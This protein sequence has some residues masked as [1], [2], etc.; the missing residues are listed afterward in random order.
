MPDATQPSAPSSSPS[1]S[2]PASPAAA[3]AAPS[4]APSN[5]SPSP[6]PAAAA[7]SPQPS[8]PVARPAYVPE[9]DWDA[10]VGK[11][12]DEKAY[13]DR[14]NNA[15]AFQAAET[16]KKLTLPQQPDGY[17]FE[18]TPNFKPPEGVSFALDPK[19][20]VVPQVQAWA[21]KHGI[22]QDALSE[23]AD[24]YAASMIG[25]QQSLKAAYNAEV[26]KLGAAGPQRIDAIVQWLNAKGGPKAATLAN[27]F[28]VAPVADTIEAV[29]H[30]MKQFS[31]QGAAP[32]SAA[33]REAPP[34][35]P[36]DATWAKMSFSE[37]MDFARRHQSPAGTQ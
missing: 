36:D 20:P 5:P 11:I 1:A 17:K 28:K 18:T 19:N 14:I 8:A 27:M 23:V 37:R 34:A 9:S 13:T 12:K 2:P 26:A 25:D 24:L 32:G 4:P 29:E 35:K 3:T 7:P 21:H 22:S 16:S 31:S 15:L 6:A 10:T 33:H 30:L